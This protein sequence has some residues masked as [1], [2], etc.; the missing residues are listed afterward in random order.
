MS[1]PRLRASLLDRPRFE[2]VPTQ[3]LMDKVDALPEG[4]IVHVMCP[5]RLEPDDTVE[6][7]A[8]LGARGLHP[9]PHLP[10]RAI[11]DRDHLR[12]LVERA[13]EAGIVDVFVPG[14]DGAPIGDYDSAVGLLEA[15]AELDHGIG[16]IGVACY[17]EGHPQIGGPVLTAALLR[18]QAVATYMVNQIVFDPLRLINGLRDI[19]ARGIELPLHAGMPGVISTIR[20]LRIARRLGVR[21]SAR[22]S[23]KQRGTLEALIRRRFAPDAILRELAHHA[24]DPTLAIAGIHLFTMNAIDTTLAWYRQRAPELTLDGQRR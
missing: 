1:E 22:L 9:V 12:R 19:R 23:Y 6:I 10:A 3:D 15:I 21:T 18:K 7:A 16:A 24:G 2:V 13:G 11:R 8:A 20:L 17:P 5:P 14:G 4:A